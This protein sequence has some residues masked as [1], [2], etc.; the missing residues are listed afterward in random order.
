MLKN[1]YHNIIYN[2]FTYNLNAMIG[3]NKIKNT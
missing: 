2:M 3:L 1:D